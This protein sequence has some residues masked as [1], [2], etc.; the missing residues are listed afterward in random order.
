MNT[1]RFFTAVFTIVSAGSALA[2]GRSL[3]LAE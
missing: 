1:L 3:T 2:D